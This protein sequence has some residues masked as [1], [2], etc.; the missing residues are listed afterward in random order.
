MHRQKIT[1]KEFK[2]QQP[3]TNCKSDEDVTTVLSTQD[4]IRPYFTPVGE[5]YYQFVFL[6]FD[7]DKSFHKQVFLL[8]SINFTL[9]QIYS[10]V[11][12]ESLKSLWK[13][14][15]QYF[16]AWNDETASPKLGLFY[17]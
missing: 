12:P 1:L 13:E 14:V 15:S 2:V 5:K 10:Y 7:A 9:S 8:L 4:R 6:F 3:E 11:T 17:P 16:E